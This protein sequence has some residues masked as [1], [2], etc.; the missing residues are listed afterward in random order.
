MKTNP[1]PIVDIPSDS[2]FL[3]AAWYPEQWDKAVHEEDMRLMRSLNMNVARVGE[4]AW[5][6]LEPK[7]G[8]FQLDWLREAL[9]LLHANGIRAVIGTPTATPPYWLM[10][11]HPEIG[12]QEADGYRHKH[13]ARQHACYN[14]PIFRQ[15]S[16]TITE[17]LAREFGRHP[18]VMAWQTDNELR[19]HQKICVCPACQASWA[20]WLEN[21]YGT[22][23]EL[24]KVWGT[25]VWSFHY[26]SFE[27]VP[28]LYRVC[29]WSHHFGLVVNYR[30]FMS[31]TAISFQDEQVQIIRAH[32]PLPVTHNSEGST[33]EWD[34][35]Q[36]LDF[37]SV[38]IYP[39]LISTMASRMRVDGL[40]S[41]KPGRRF[42]TM[43]T[44]SDSMVAERMKAGEVGCFGF[45][46]YVSGSQAMLYWCWRQHRTG[47]EIQHVS[48][49]YSNGQPTPGWDEVRRVSESRQKLE[50]ILRDYSTSP[51]DV[52]IIWSEKNANHFF[53][54]GLEANFSYHAKMAD[55]YG[56]L[57]EVGAWRDLVSDE[58]ALEGYKIIFSPYLPYASPDFLERMKNH[59]NRDGAWV[60]GPYCGYRERDHTVPTNAI[61]GQVEKMLG[62]KTKFFCP[63]TN[64]DVSLS[65]GIQ[66]MTRMYATVFDSTP[67][68]EVLGVYSHGQFENL[69]WGVCRP[70]GKGRVYV[71]GSEIDSPARAHLY[72][73]I[74]DRE[75][76]ERVV[77]PLSVTLSPQITRDGRKAWALSSTDAATQEIAL[78]SPGRDL[79][80]GQAVRG[81]VKLPS[82]TNAFIAFD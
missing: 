62:F 23:D 43:E 3:G 79:L 24:N 31:D 5:S 61:L 75:K 53:S 37:A 12:Y 21:R 7:E 27:D 41:I 25:N 59:L 4:F 80:T 20:K 38:D 44:G 66:A 18:A 71:L 57:I 82:C 26:D 56:T 40:R 15:H 76:V 47:T 67:D 39:G 81:K 73:N 35:F 68:D 78:P 17:V 51:A 74:L 45:L 46:N 19:C 64:L 60:V 33:D 50:P 69:A 36:G 10:K 42:W 65:S 48:L 28:P 55:Q 6:K 72:A 34:L 1:T 2:L 77:L 30:R 8:T 22:V 70:Y 9:D 49:V 29:C 32:S 63:G 58:S 14:N 54:T 13:G 11:K 16:R 52:A